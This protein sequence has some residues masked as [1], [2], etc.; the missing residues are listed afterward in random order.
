MNN[1]RLWLF[2]REGHLEKCFDFF[3]ENRNRL[4]SIKEIK[5]YFNIEDTI[6]DG[7]YD[8][9][10]EGENG[11]PAHIDE[12]KFILIDTDG[13][14]L[15]L[16]ACNC[17]YTGGGP[18]TS[19]RILKSLR[20]EGT[21][22][23]DEF[24]DDNIREILTARK[25]N[26]TAKDEGGWTIY[27]SP[28][29]FPGVSEGAHLILKGKT[30]ILV[31]DLNA[32]R[33]KKA[34]EIYETYKAFIP[35]PERIIIFPTDELSKAAGYIYGRF[36]TPNAY[37]VIISDYSGREIWLKP[38][39]VEA[40]LLKCEEVV[41]ILNI[42]GFTLEDEKGKKEYE[43]KGKLQKGIMFLN[44]LANGEDIKPFIFEHE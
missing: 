33:S 30:P 17:G 9:T 43:S 32:F 1:E 26:I 37:S 12:A 39:G 16:G 5:V 41:N 8:I 35:E 42:C 23:A 28:S 27:T 44:T 25:V 22:P 18:G 36:G 15:W 13:N 19:G 29:P 34:D 10:E 2:E 21:L 14:E 40:N 38:Y 20:D 4:G 3:K 24:T 11:L 6:V 7:Y 31:Q